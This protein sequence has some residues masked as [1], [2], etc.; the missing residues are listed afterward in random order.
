MAETRESGVT[1][2]LTRSGKRERPLNR[3]CMEEYAGSRGTRLTALKSEYLPA[4]EL[5]HWK[6]T[7]QAR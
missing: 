1:P 4:A 2:E 6:Q 3:H 5:N 7:L